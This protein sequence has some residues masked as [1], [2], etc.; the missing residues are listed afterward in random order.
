MK[1]ALVVLLMLAV[2]SMASASPF[3]I[4]EFNNTSNLTQ[5][6]VCTDLAL[7]GSVTAAA[8]VDASDGA[9]FVG[10]GSYLTISGMGNGT[11]TWS[12]MMDIM[13]PQSTIG[14]YQSLYQT[15][16]TNENDGECFI[17][18]TR[19]DIGGSVTGYSTNTVVAD[20]WYRV[21]VAWNISTPSY[22]LYV[23]G[24]LWRDT[25]NN[26]ADLYRYDLDN[27]LHLFA[28]E[29]GEDPGIYV[30]NAAFWTNQLSA[31]DAAALGVAGNAIPE[32]ATICLLS[33]GA[34]SLIRRKK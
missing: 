20:T 26:P 5:A 21:I 9:A 33:L 28:D 27:I 2:A 24:V 25:I 11:G 34:I 7:T 29:D 8:G 1:R 6:T 18:N 15:S 19:H 4:W 12:L 10:Q 16:P 23:D 32:P 17:H 13:L 31:A 30:S 14:Q 22:G 3:G